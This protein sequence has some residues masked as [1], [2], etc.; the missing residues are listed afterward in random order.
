VRSQNQ[1][2]ER[3]QVKHRFHDS[4]KQCFVSGTLSNGG[5]DCAGN[6]A[7]GF[8]FNGNPRQHRS[9]SKKSR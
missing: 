8:A 4:N 6:P 5:G 1:R 9:D 3:E 2:A 7:S